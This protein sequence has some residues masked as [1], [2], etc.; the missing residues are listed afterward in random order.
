MVALIPDTHQDLLDRPIYVVATTLM[1]DGTPQS[2]VVWWD[3][4]GDTIRLNTVRGRQKDKNL[5][6]DP[7]ITILAVDP[8]NGYHWLEVR[9]VV[10]SV[11]EEG[12]RDHIEK[13]S[14]KYQNEKYY[15]GFNKVRKPEDETRL[16]VNIR[17]VRVRH[18][19]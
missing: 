19:T 9:G 10:E 16:I 12:G 4:E 11:V 18:S 2:S 14:W 15:G 13:L 1:P 5:Q 17:P 7:R 8:A 3:Y 6:R